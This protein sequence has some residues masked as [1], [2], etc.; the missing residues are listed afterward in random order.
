MTLSEAQFKG[1]V[2]NA[3]SDW[4]TD[5]V[6]NYDRLADR[7]MKDGR[8][9]REIDKRLQIHQSAQKFSGPTCNTKD[10][11]EEASLPKVLDEDDN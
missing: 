1:G 3:V 2:K 5:R 11:K 7:L 4:F 10:K 9:A 6:L 8:L